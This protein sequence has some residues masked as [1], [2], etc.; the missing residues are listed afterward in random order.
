MGSPWINSPSNNY[1]LV[2]FNVPNYL[3]TNFDELVKFKRISRTS[4]LITLMESYIRTEVLKLKEDD[5]INK[6]I[7]NVKLRNNT[8]TQ[9]LQKNNTNQSPATP[10]FS[11]NDMGEVSRW[12]DSFKDGF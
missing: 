1:K 6:L 4:M 9:T 5:N 8:P 11:D 3:I 10:M 2:N 12:E 7:T